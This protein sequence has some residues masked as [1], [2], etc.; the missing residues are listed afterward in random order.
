L[1]DTT[2]SFNVNTLPGLVKVQANYQVA[3]DRKKC[4]TNSDSESTDVSEKR[5]V[6]VRR[7]IE[8]EHVIMEEDTNDFLKALLQKP[9]KKR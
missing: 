3:R 5:A 4:P 2:G 9:T 8:L 1:Y 7:V 6:A